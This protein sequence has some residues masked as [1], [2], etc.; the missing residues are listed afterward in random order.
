V[1]DDGTLPHAP[2]AAKPALYQYSAEDR[3]VRLADVVIAWNVFQHFYP[4]FDVVKTDWA[5]ELPKAL[6][7]AATD[8]GP[9]EFERPWPGWSPPS[10]TGT[11]ASPGPISGRSSCRR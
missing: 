5:A 1:D 2:P 9:A 3:A 10:R 7:T 4:Y 8:P 11:A 6:R